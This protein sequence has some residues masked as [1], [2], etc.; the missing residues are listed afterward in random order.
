MDPTNRQPDVAEPCVESPFGGRATHLQ[1]LST[2]HITELYRKKCGANVERAFHG[3]TLVHLYRCETT[4]YRFWRPETIAGDESFYKELSRSWGQYYQTDR[5]EYAQAR[6][7][8]GKSDSV[9]EIGCGRGYFLRSIEGLVGRAQGIE[10]NRD[11]IAKKVTN[12]PVEATSLDSYHTND[13][14]GFDAVCAFQVLEHIAAPKEFIQAALDRL[15]PGGILVL[16]T[17]NFGYFQYSEQIDPFDLPPHHMGH[18]QEST[19]K[20]IGDLFGLEVVSLTSEPRTHKPEQV[21][22]GTS[23]SYVF[24]LARS[25]S[26]VAYS[27]A[28]R[29]SSEPGPN[30]LVIL[31]KPL[32]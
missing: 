9:L 26:R 11:A 32:L 29:V 8:F 27:T 1:A 16:S 31:R 19:F 15:R 3:H 2:S 5:W 12:F 28:F 10:L 13:G 21:S 14:S 24:R 23:K 25:I 22:D 17:P 4:G 7:A 18:F 6:A 20:R 30:L